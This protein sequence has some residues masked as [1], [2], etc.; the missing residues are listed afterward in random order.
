MSRI[1]EEHLVRH[2]QGAKGGRDVALLDI[3][4]D[5][6]LFLLHQA[7]LFN[8]GLVFKG[9]TALRKFRAGN[10][11]RFSTDLDFTAPGDNLPLAALEALDGAGL[12]GF[13]FAVENLGDDGRRGDLRIETPFGR[14]NLGAKIELARHRLSLI[15]DVLDPIRLPIHRRYDST[16]PP[17]PVIRTEEA[18]TEKLARFRRVSLARDLYDLQWYATNGIMNEPLVRR[19]WVLKVYRDVVA[20]GRGTPPIE[21]DDILAARTSSDFRPEDIGYLTKPVRIDEWIATVRTHYAFLADFDADEYRWTQC[22]GGDRYEVETT[23]ATIEP[24]K[25]HP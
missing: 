25:R 4:Q 5:H 16:V 13:S 15:P 9:G 23:L 10:S 18:I 24:T 20:D 17:T 8:Q 2:Y 14:P 21:P 19:L 12:D 6:A 22:N 1:T 7:G 3:A 11:G